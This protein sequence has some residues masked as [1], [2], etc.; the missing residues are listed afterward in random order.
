MVGLRRRPLVV[1][2]FAKKNRG[3]TPKVSAAST[4]TEKEK[5]ESRF[6]ALRRRTLALWAMCLARLRESVSDAKKQGS[7]RWWRVARTT[8]ILG[9]CL[10]L[11]A[12]KTKVT[13]NPSPEIVAQSLEA[14]PASEVAWSSFLQALRDENGVSEVVVS[15]SR[16]DFVR[17]DGSRFFAVPVP[18]ASDVLDMMLKAGATVRAAPKAG[19]SALQVVSW[20]VLLTYLAVLSGAA[21]QMFRGGVGNVSRRAKMGARAKSDPDAVT[22]DM[23]AGI[24]EARREVEELRDLV[25]SSKKYSMAGAR[26]PKGVLLVGPPGTGK[27]MLARALATE[28]KVPFLYCSGSDFIE[29]FAGR[30][31]ARVRQLFARASKLAPCIL[32]IDELDALGKARRDVPGISGWNDESEQTLNQLLAAMDGV[33]QNRGIV[34]LAATNRLSVLDQAL[35][36]PGRFDRIVQ[37]PPPD[38]LGRQQILAIHAR[39]LKLDSS[40]DLLSIAAITPGLVGADLAAII[41]EAAIRA[42]RA[43]RDVVL[44][45][46]LKDAVDTYFKT[47][48]NKRPTIFDALGNTF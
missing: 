41:N 36:R 14:A 33:E 24:G 20:I 6:K 32:F 1:S 26:A 17:S 39:K 16:Y 47:R 5:E 38:L 3:T 40:V 8:V 19:A 34:V 9:V 27:T 2:C 29:I 28:A 21:R 44:H 23:I 15:A 18:I 46:D 22:F 4:A 30:G 43:E 12:A 31:A 37:V 45:A 35:V 11:Y 42:V 48:P 13:G 10:L 25:S 7:S